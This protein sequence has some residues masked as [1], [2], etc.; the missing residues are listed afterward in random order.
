MND[1]IAS[2]AA[3]SEEAVGSLKEYIAEC[4]DDI[5]QARAARDLSVRLFRVRQGVWGDG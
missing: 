4:E 2:G 1:H 3:P 5:M